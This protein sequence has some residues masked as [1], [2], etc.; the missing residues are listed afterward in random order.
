MS[1][2]SSD[3]RRPGKWAA[4]PEGRPID[5]TTESTES[6]FGGLWRAKRKEAVSVES[7]ERPEEGAASPEWRTVG[8]R[9]L[10]EDAAAC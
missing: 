4:S 9:H 6:R 3:R 10:P 2:M 8:A 1:S 5:I 7:V